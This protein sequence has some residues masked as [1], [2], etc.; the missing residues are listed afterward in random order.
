MSDE[1]KKA[2]IVRLF[3]DHAKPEPAGN[4][5]SIVINGDGNV[6]GNGNTVV[7]TESYRPKIKVEYH[8]DDGHITPEQAATL[9]R[10]VGEIVEAETVLKQ[11]PKSFGAVYSAL[12][13][14]FRVN[15][16]LLIPRED[17]DQAERYLRSW[18][19]R[20]SSARSAPKKD[21]NWRDRK[22]KF[23]FANTKG[24]L[25]DRRKTYM[26]GRFGT[27]SFSVLDDEQVEQLYRAVADWKQRTERD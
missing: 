27:E 11:R 12:N 18:L 5:P 20:L 9:K 1:E 10:L 25:D 2:E 21:P 14:R 19:G 24:V 23:I 26:L 13:Q 15:T 6:V 22:R 8:P 7:K 3:K 17:Y 4:S 16:Y